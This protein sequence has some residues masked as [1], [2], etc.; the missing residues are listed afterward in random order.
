MG[1]DVFI[2]RYGGEEFVLIFK[3]V[4]KITVMNR[5]NMLRKKV[6]SLPFTFKGTRVTITLS[7][8]VTL[9]QRDD[10]VHSA[11]ERAD[12]ALYRAKHEGK[13]KV[14]YG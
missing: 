7:I 3:D 2:S 9:V 1:N 12:T 13:N 10:I 11:F 5:L 6:A 4:D 8:G 14:V